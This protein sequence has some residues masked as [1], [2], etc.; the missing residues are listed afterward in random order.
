MLL[1]DKK[2]GS[3]RAYFSKNLI[4]ALL[5][6]VSFN[7]FLST[8]YQTNYLNDNYFLLA[9]FV[10][11][12]LYKSS[13]ELK[14]ESKGITI[15]RNGTVTANII[16]SKV[17]NYEYSNR[18]L[19][20][21]TT[22]G[23]IFKIKLIKVSERDAQKLVGFISEQFEKKPIEESTYIPN[24]VA[25]KDRIINLVYAVG[26]SSYAAYGL[27][28]D[29]MYMG[30][31]VHL[32][33]KSVYF[34]F[35]AMMSAVIVMLTVLFDHYDRRDNEQMYRSIASFFKFTGWFLFIVAYIT[36]FGS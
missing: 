8:L 27:Y 13:Y 31:G 22:D 10:L 34:M 29:D 3:S 23:A 33:G 15:I 28:I 35:A 6:W 36:S 7:L 4:L 24:F 2:I 1:T 16:F 25:L 9:I 30:D 14:I 11:I 19:R 18:L 5:S 17:L 12:A 32:V 26:L 21:F 20:I